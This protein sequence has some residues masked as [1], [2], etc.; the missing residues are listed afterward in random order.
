MVFEWTK[1]YLDETYRI[2]IGIARKRVGVDC[3]FRNWERT[4][5]AGFA[6]DIERSP[7]A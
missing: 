5:R 3:R 7:I 4:T 1:L 2:F 6:I